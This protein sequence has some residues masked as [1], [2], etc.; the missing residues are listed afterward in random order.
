MKILLASLVLAFSVS[1]YAEGCNKASWVF[2]PKLEDKT[3]TLRIKGTCTLDKIGNFESLKDHY[4]KQVSLNSD[5]VQVHSTNENS[6]V[7]GL[8]ATEIDSTIDQKAEEDEMTVRYVTKV[9]TDGTARLVFDQDSKKFV[10]T[11]G[12]TKY[13][14]RLY[15][16]IN[17]KKGPNGVVI[18]MV[19][20]TKI[21]HP[22][23]SWGMDQA[24]EG[25]Q[26]GF[27]QTL[28][29]TFQDISVNF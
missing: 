18:E 12:N 22:M 6:T 4:V 15:T 9:G 29:D 2:P 7:D 25:V 3:L 26:K 11:K 13:L 10:K 1:S 20:E 16:N 21:T 28:Q 27:K 19:Q 5:V 24:M 17:V 23:I 14:T 8:K